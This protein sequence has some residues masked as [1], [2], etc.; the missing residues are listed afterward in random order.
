MATRKRTTTNETPAATE[1]AGV[2][3]E[4]TSAETVDQV[5]AAALERPAMPDL[6]SVGG[7]L[8]A[9]RTRF[10]VADPKEY[11]KL[12]NA[13]GTVVFWAEIDDSLTIREMDS[14]PAALSTTYKEQMQY[15]ARFVYSWNAWAFDETTNSYIP[16]PAPA[17]YGW[18]ILESQPRQVTSFLVAALKFGIGSD[19]PKLR[20]SSSNTDSGADELILD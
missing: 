1:A 13:D 20:N 12:A 11:S 9:K 3:P 2:S 5:P 6:T 4:P 14:I 16:A 10:V 17:D 18:T 7:W 8:P 19:V 15:I